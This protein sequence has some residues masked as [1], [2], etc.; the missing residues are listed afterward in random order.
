[1]RAQSGSGGALASSST[2]EL[3]TARKPFLNLCDWLRNTGR[4][5]CRPGKARP[6]TLEKNKR[7]RAPHNVA[8]LKGGLVQLRAMAEMV[9]QTGFGERP[10]FVEQRGKFLTR[11]EA[12]SW[13]GFFN[14]GE[15]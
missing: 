9:R 11:L 13:E 15:S 12:G 5:E 6:A 2:P 1:M 14:G 4:K 3:M 10:S 8:F 7:S